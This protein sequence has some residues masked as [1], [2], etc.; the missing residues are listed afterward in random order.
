VAPGLG[1]GEEG[2]L[3]VE[4][5]KCVGE[6]MSGGKRRRE[7]IRVPFLHVPGVLIIC[8]H[9]NGS[10]SSVLSVEADH[11]QRRILLVNLSLPL[12]LSSALAAA[13]ELLLL[14]ILLL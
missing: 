3:V 11:L 7:N 10:S 1:D 13:A 6:V 14:L 4:R 9:S 8:R 5:G 2:G 12:V